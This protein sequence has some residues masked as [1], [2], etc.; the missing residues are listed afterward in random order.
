MKMLAFVQLRTTGSDPKT[1]EIVEIG[2]VRLSPRN[3]EKM[4]DMQLRVKPA[5]AHL[6]DPKALKASGY[7]KNEWW[8]ALT[9]KEAM[10][11][12]APNLHRTVLCGHDVART[13]AFL[14]AAWEQTG[15]TPAEFVTPMLDTAELVRPLLAMGKARSL[16]LKVVSSGMLRPSQTPSNAL[17]DARRSAAIACA[18][19]RKL[20]SFDPV[21]T[22][23]VM[24][25]PS[26][27]PPSLPPDLSMDMPPEQDPEEALWD[28]A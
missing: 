14:D 22:R 16:D 27:D 17:G 11:Q 19:F 21:H 25:K 4:S 23:V 15:I 24:E 1:S 8:D 18:L 13:R 28:V 6:A 9:L 20:E 3:L 26:N 10:K 5:H 12:L 7:E 2:L